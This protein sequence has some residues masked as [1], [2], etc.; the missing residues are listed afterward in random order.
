MSALT[1]AALETA[2]T[3]AGITRFLRP[4]DAAWEPTNPRVA[5][6]VTTDR[7]DQVKDNVGS[8]VGRTRL[9]KLT[10]ERGSRRDDHDSVVHHHDQHNTPAA[11][12]DDDDHHGSRPA[13]GIVRPD[14]ERSLP[15]GFGPD[16]PPPPAGRLPGPH[17]I[18]VPSGR[19]V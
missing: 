7:Y 10:L 14:R 12:D 11:A 4:E 6:F 17:L 19:D 18:G 2:S 5:Y 13:S 3:A 9:W 8:Q 15:A 1:G 16:R